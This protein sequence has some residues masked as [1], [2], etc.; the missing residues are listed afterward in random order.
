MHVF[1]PV[2]FP[3]ASDAWYVPT[4]SET[5]TAA[6]LDQVPAAHAVQHALIVGPNSGYGL[7]NRCLLDALAHSQ[8]RYKGVAVVGVALNVA[9]LGVDFYRNTGPLLERL[10]ELAMWAQDQVQADELV[11][12]KPMLQDS[13]VHLLFDHCGRP[14]PQAGVGQA[15]F[16]ALLALAQTGCA[17]V[18]L[19]S[20]T[21]CSVQPYPYADAWP[22]VQALVEAYRGDNGHGKRAGQHLQSGGAGQGFF[23][24]AG[25]GGDEVAG[26]QNDCQAQKAGQLQPD[27]ACQVLRGHSV[28]QQLVASAIAPGVKIEAGISTAF[29]C[30]IQGIVTDDDVVWTADGCIEAGAEEA[31]LSDTTGMANLAQVKHLFNKVRSAIGDKT[32]AAHLHNTRGMGGCPYAPGPP[33]T[34]SRKTWCSCSKPWAFRPA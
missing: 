6:N 2:R 22:Y 11:T 33:A 8:G 17:C 26:G 30:T 27:I 12:L 7:D 31:G 34:W 15:G 20:L 10:R 1:D 29:G 16:A 4:G 21:K 9:L 32:G 13:G 28:V 24:V 19:S 5:G 18:K 3:Y 14:H 23:N 25:Q